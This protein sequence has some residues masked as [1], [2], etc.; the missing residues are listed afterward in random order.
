MTIRF[1][2]NMAVTTLIGVFLVAASYALLAV[3][4]NAENTRLY[5]HMRELAQLTSDIRTDIYYQLAVAAGRVTPMPEPAG[6]GWPEYALEDIDIQIALADSEAERDHWQRLRRAIGAMDFESRSSSSDA[7]SAELLRVAEHH[8]RALRSAYSLR[9]YDAIAAAASTSFSAQVAIAVACVLTV[10]LFLSYLIMVRDWLVKPIEVLKKSAD[11]IGLGGLE[12]RVPLKGNNELVEL[13]TRLDAMA[14][15]LT[16]HQRALLEA[17]E[18]S[19]IGELCTNVAHG[20]RNPLASLRASAQ[21]AGRRAGDPEETKL[22]A[23]EIIRQVDR[24]DGRITRLFEFSRPERMNKH[25]TTFAELAHSARAEVLTLLRE[26]NVSLI[27]EDRTD[28]NVWCMDRRQLAAVLSELVTNAVHHSESGGQ[29]VMSGCAIVMG[30][31]TA[32]QLQVEVVD[33]GSGMAEATLEKAFDLF[34]TNRRDGTGMGLAMVRRAVQRH[35]GDVRISSEL[36]C[37]TT[38]TITV[39][40]WCAHYTDQDWAGQDVPDGKQCRV[41]GFGGD[42]TIVPPV[43]HAEP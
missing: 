19:A 23:L 32:K 9:E 33:G 42:G 30:S 24:L 27:I 28:R 43:E 25:C 4:R 18:L 22:A 35:G 11:T 14:Q 31:D 6:A 40:G 34:F 26:K 2:L 37:G 13:G 29:I 20:L 41:C 36:G 16:E 17:R 39:P 3:N 21:L 10:V 8:L 38:A 15:R 7:A 12:H 1:K 5:S